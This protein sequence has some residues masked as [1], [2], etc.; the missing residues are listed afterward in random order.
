M[1]IID[2]QLRDRFT[3]TQEAA[4]YADINFDRLCRLRALRHEAFSLA[5]LFRAAQRLDVKFRI[6]IE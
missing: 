6:V 4:D 3:T 2:A 1:A 5:W